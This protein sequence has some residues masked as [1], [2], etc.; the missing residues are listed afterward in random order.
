MSVSLRNYSKGSYQPGAGILKRVLWYMLNAIFFD[1]YICPNSKLK[2]GLLRLFGANIGKDVV[3]KPRVNIKYPWLL[4]IGDRVWLGERVWIDNLTWVT[5]YSDVCISQ[6]A[7][8]LTG[9]HDYKDP[10]FGLITKGIEIGKG[11]WIGAR[12]TVCPGIKVGECAVL[13]VGSVLQKDAQAFGIYQGNP[14]SFKKNR[15]FD[16]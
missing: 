14:A 6:E 8:L 7:Y 11:A 12:T 15:E 1:S 3:V 10:N 13:T 4:K 16:N 5:I 2:C 9:N